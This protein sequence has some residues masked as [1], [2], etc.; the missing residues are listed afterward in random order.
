MQRAVLLLLALTGPCS[1]LGCAA[2]AFPELPPAPVVLSLPDC[3]AP[4][5]PT[6]PALDE[7]LPLDGPLNTARLM[8]RDDRFRAYLNALRAT[9]TCYQQK[10][11]PNAH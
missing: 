3:P 10:R 11:E 9:L 7:A 8:E 6:L 5:V 1:L 4:A 2:Q